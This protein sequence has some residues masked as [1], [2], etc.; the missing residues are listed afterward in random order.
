MTTEQ[1]ALIAV[2]ALL[3]IA[4]LWGL[5]IWLRHSA[6]D[7]VSPDTAYTRGLTAL[8]ERRPR[9]ALQALKEAVQHD[10]ENL[11]AYIRLGDLLRESGDVSR[12]LAVHRDLTVRPRLVD[13][14]RIRILESL[15]K[16]YLAA[17][18][19]E[20]AGTSAER[21]REIQRVNRFAYDALRRVAEALEDWDRAVQAV[22]DEVRT[23][24]DGGDPRRALYRVTVG[25]R[26]L[27]AGSTDSARKR[28]EEAIKL[29]S[30]CLPAYVMLGDMDEASGNLE[31]AVDRWKDMALRDPSR[32][33]E[34]FPRLER[35]FFELGQFGEVISFYREILHRTVADDAGPALLA[36]AEIHRRKGEQAEAE[37]FVREAL[38]VDPADPMA[39]RL[40]IKLA[41][42]KED[43]ALA[44]DLL[45]R[46][47]NVSWQDSDQIAV[48]ETGEPDRLTTASSLT[49]PLPTPKS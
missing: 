22:D 19:F 39:H 25:R 26:E 18:R 33:R 49:L 34:V 24:G 1:L 44:L 14:D 42:D 15:T 2:G 46:F 8:I 4:V 10:S 40:Q 3:V 20:E 27:E 16:D 41:L 23:T 7:G 28:F 12:A 45:E 21:L 29:D 11:D 38:E 35:A 36:L 17:E 37:G 47:L 31:K 9:L 32:A 6:R 43:P 48:P 5:W 13:T 30:D